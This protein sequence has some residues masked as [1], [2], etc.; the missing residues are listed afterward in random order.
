M[1]SEVEFAQENTASVPCCCRNGRWV[2]GVKYELTRQRTVSAMA[3]RCDVK[4]VR[5][6]RSAG[7]EVQGCHR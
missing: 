6:S 7:S 2:G 1:V 4:M 5:T 3:L